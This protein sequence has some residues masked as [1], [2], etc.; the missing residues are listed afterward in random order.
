MLTLSVTE[1]NKSLLMGAYFAQRDLKYPTPAQRQTCDPAALS[2]LPYYREWLSGFI[3]AE[4]CFSVRA[5]KLTASFSIGQKF[6]SYLLHSIRIYLQ[7]TA[8][9]NLRKDEADFYYFE[10]YSRASLLK[11]IEHCTLYPLLGEKV[12]QFTAFTSFIQR[13]PPTK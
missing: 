1:K 9:V 8:N 3:E 13:L 4:G 5:N 10:T 7:A 6:D 12:V 11:V 2:Q